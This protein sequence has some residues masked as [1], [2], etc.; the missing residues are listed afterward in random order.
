[1]QSGPT[2]VPVNAHQLTVADSITASVTAGSPYATLNVTAAPNKGACPNNVIQ[3]GAPYGTQIVYQTNNTDTA[4]CGTGS[5]LIYPSPGS[6]GSTTMSIG[7]ATVGHMVQWNNTS[8]AFQV[9]GD[10]F[11]FATGASQG[12]IINGSGNATSAA[13]PSGD[14]GNYYLV[15]PHYYGQHTIGWKGNTYTNQLSDLSLSNVTI[16]SSPG[17]CVLV[18]NFQRGFAMSGGG[19]VPFTNDYASCE[20]DGIDAVLGG[21]TATGVQSGGDII[22]DSATLNGTGDD[23]FNAW[24][25]PFDV[26][27][28]GTDSIGNNLVTTATAYNSHISVGDVL[29]FFNL[30]TGAFIGTTIVTAAGGGSISYAG[31]IG[32]ITSCLVFLDETLA[33][34]R[35][36]IT[37]NTINKIEGR[38]VV[39][40]EPNSYVYNNTIENNFN[41]CIQAFQDFGLFLEGDGPTN[42]VITTNN[43]TNNGN[44]TT[45]GSLAPL[46]TGFSDAQIWVYSA[47]PGAAPGTE[48]AQQ[49]ISIT[50]NTVTDSPIGCLGATATWNVSMT[51]NTCSTTNTANPR[52]SSISAMT[53]GYITITG[54]TRTETTDSGPIYI[55][56]TVSVPLN[57]QTSY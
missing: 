14:V 45:A 20:Y 15:F 51:S 7:S 35:I 55:D 5:Y 41:T 39:L 18:E 16:K 3:S 10:K 4:P 17:A 27:A 13:F 42:S 50:G 43:C 19:F 52:A 44:P 9:G 32:S 57:V 8:H 1:M 23:A 40:Q 6:I 29:A 49:N 28:I 11:Y 22:V 36:A 53:S 54:N 37:G 48:I 31:P 38:G 33:M 34:N 21:A 2:L 24:N 26:S 30:N 47:L 56:G 25:Q 46:P 12:P